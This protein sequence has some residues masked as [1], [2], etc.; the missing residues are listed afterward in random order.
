MS[1]AI[2]TN[3][4][5]VR[6]PVT[7]DTRTLSELVR[8]ATPLLHE[9]A[10]RAHVMVIPPVTWSTRDGDDGLELVASADATLLDDIAEQA[11]AKRAVVS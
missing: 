1:H 10:S 9:I 8:E 4:Y 3:R 5:E 6:W 2:R 11:L 7:D